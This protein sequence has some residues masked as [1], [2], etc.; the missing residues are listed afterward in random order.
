MCPCVAVEAWL[1]IHALTHGPLFV[2]IRRYGRLTADRLGGSA[3]GAIVK[4]YAL[5][6]GMDPKEFGGH[7]LRAGFATQAILNN[8]QDQLV[9]RQTRHKSAAVFAKYVRPAKLF[10]DN[11]S[12]KVGL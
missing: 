9:M 12:G 11:A 6:A 4:R 1:K 10:R 2:H 3:I 7:S 5:A 8:V